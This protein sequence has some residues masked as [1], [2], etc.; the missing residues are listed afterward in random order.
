MNA[1]YSKN[2]KINLKALKVNFCLKLDLLLATTPIHIFMPFICNLR[3]LHLLF[4]FQKFWEF[5]LEID[6]HRGSFRVSDPFLS[7]FFRDNSFQCWKFKK[8]G[9]SCKHEKQFEWLKLFKQ[10]QILWLLVNTWNQLSLCQSNL[11]CQSFQF[12][13]ITIKQQ[14]KL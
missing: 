11:L 14:T 6:V 12:N 7:H 9:F 13:E 1:T 10:N 3:F 5:E 8:V 2:N 4:V